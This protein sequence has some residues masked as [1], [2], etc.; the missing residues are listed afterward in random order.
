MWFWPVSSDSEAKNNHV[1]LLWAALLP[2][3]GGDREG[4][5]N[6]TAGDQPRPSPPGAAFWP[7]SGVCSVGAS[8]ASL[9]SCGLP[10]ALARNFS[11]FFFFLARSRWRF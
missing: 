8:G 9:P 7:E 6:A 2:A 4:W 1:G 5:L 3:G 11:S 10:E